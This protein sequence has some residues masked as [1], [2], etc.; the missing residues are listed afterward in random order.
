MN[1]FKIGDTVKFINDELHN[2]APRY[3]PK[4]GTI[5]EIVKLH[6]G[7]TMFV[8]WPR[9][10][11][12]SDDVWCVAGQDIELVAHKVDA[13]VSDDQIWE[14]LK[15]KMEKL[16]IDPNGSMGYLT[17]SSY[18]DV[19]TKYVMP[20]EDVKRLV[21]TVYRSGYGRGKKN[22][23]FIIGEKKGHWEQCEGN[24]HP[25]VGTKL[26]RNSFINNNYY[27]D[28]IPCGTIVNVIKVDGWDDYHVWITYSN[29]EK[30]TAVEKICVTDQ[31]HYFDRW[32]EE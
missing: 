9:G 11:T 21:A 25:S 12:S 16:K 28:K 13:S 32:V 31:L 19:D 4:G 18:G 17:L 22:R 20:I 27:I 3:Y 2:D 10:S 8:Q 14:M 30:D 6:E 1:K 29:A 23:P 5:G 7:N 15:P 26:R 24:Y